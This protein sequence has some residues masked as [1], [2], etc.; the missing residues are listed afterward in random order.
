MLLQKLS[1]SPFF[2]RYLNRYQSFFYLYIL[3]LCISLITRMGLGIWSFSEIDLSL[4]NILSVLIIGWLYD[5]VFFLY[6]SIP[7]IFIYWLV[8]EKIWHKQWFKGGIKLWFVVTVYI[9]CFIVVSEFIFWDEFQVRFNF[10]SV[11]YLVY[12]KE[13]ID[14]I[15]ES[16]PVLLILSLIIPITLIIAFSLKKIINQSLNV[17]SNITQRTVTSLF[18]LLLTV[19]AYQFVDQSQFNVFKNNYNRQLAANGPYQFFAAFR[20]NQLDYDYF[21]KHIEPEVADKVI[22]NSLDNLYTTFLYPDEPMNIGRKIDNPGTEKKLNVILIS[23]ESLSAKYLG[24]FGN[25]EK[26]TPFMDQLSQES[27]FFT[28][29]Y[30]VGTRTTRGLEAITLSIPPT[31]GRSIVKRIGSE[32]DYWSLGNVFKKKGYQTNFIYGGRGYFDNMTSFFTKNGYDVIDQTDIPDEEVKFS[33]AWGV[34]DEDLYEETIKQADKAFNNSKPFF[35][36][37]MTTSNHRPYTYPENKIDIPSGDGRDGSVKYSDFALKRFVNWA[38]TKPWF[39]DTVFVITADHCA[40]SAGKEDLPVKKYHIPFMIYAPEHIRNN[41][42]S[43][44]YS[45]IDIAPT[46]LGLLNFDYNSWFF[47]QDILKENNTR[48]LALISNYQYLGLYLNELVTVLKPKKEVELYKVQSSTISK[49]QLHVSEQ[50]DY[51]NKTIAYYQTA[52]W[53]LKHKI[54]S[55]SENQKKL[56]D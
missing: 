12:R 27:L 23:I 14:N 48:Q 54:N 25:K 45:Q 22:R 4:L 26:L 20:N 1:N 56:M 52:A 18:L 49:P 44:R 37:I 40:G 19:A 43:E 29:F 21:Y 28:Q 7:L 10:I 8:P 33:N 32:G 47:G 11:D 36:H 35:F 16:Y 2:S 51:I 46:I 53:M 17:H 15:N 50:K 3:F 42:I 31:P 30:A 24:V 5:T 41:V 39:K 6:A 9:L 55:W 38:K 13:V 34:S